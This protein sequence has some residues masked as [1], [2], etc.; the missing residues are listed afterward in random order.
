MRLSYPNYLTNCIDESIDENYYS[1]MW[2]DYTV[3]V[4]LRFEPV[5]DES[6]SASGKA[7]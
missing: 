7:A 6:G 2:C 5:Y 3:R 1:S 4:F